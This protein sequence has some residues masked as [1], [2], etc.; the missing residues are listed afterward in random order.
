MIKLEKKIESKQNES[1]RLYFKSIIEPGNGR[2][3]IDYVG[4]LNDNLQGFYKTRCIN[5]DLSRGL[6]AVTQ[7]EV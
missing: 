6:A 2:L 7:F 1:V 4:T 3:Q 5:K